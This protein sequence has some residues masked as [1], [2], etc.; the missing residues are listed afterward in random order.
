MTW[1]RSSD[2][3]LQIEDR[4]A[5]IAAE[6]HVAPGLAQNMRDQRRR[7]RFAIGAGDGDE[8]RAAGVRA[9]ARG[10]RVR[11]RR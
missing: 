8:G 5:D 4:H 2:G 11:C 10:R 1:M 3:R 9:R 6:L 7:R